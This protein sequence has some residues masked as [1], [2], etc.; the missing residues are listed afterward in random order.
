MGASERSKG[1]RVER[2]ITALHQDA[3][4][5]CEKVSRSGNT[6]ED[7]RIAGRLKGER[8]GQ[9]EAPKT[10]VGWLGENDLLFIKPDR[11]PPLVVMPWST[12]IELMQHLP[13]P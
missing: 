4:I 8:K 7:L 11:Q 5:L 6:S 3:G 2:A 12:Y 1:A 10:I 9:K 13:Q